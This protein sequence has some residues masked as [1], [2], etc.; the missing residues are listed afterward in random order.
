[1]LPVL[2]NLERALEHGEKS[3]AESSIV[4]GVKMVFRQFVGALTKHG[5]VGF[6][7]VGEVFDP[8]RHEAIQQVETADHETGV[9][10]EQFQK[11]Y[12]LHER[13]LR[14]AM[15]S[16]SRKIEEVAE[17]AP[18]DEV[19]EE[20]ADEPILEEIP[21]SELSEDLNVEQNDG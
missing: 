18:V 15:V 13:L 1:M 21:D 16:V 20:M 4:D 9:V 7:S 19:A 11:G 10:L 6:E 2:D 3:E 12:F 5:V 8:Q 14:P 17:V